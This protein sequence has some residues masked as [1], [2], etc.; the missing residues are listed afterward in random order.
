VRRTIVLLVAFFVF[1]PLTTQAQTRRRSTSRAPSTTAARPSAAVRAGAVRVSDQVKNLTRFIFL[2]G[3]VAKS[4]EQTE[5][6]IGRSGA[7]PAIVDQVKRSK[8]TVRTSLRGVRE[9]LDKLEIDFRTMPE[10]QR[11]YIKLAGSAAGAARAEEL[12]AAN[13]YDRAGRELVEVVNR[14]ADVLLEMP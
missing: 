12:A 11:Y 9:G 8:D 4:I 7:S 10:L 6:A 13:Q 2:L 1:A 5:L 3:G 14:L